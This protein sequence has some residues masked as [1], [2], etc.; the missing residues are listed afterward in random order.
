MTRKARAIGRPAAFILVLILATHAGT[1]QEH[2]NCGHPVPDRSIRDC[3]LLVD[4]GGTAAD[5]LAEFHLLRGLAHFMKEETDQALADFEVA[6][7]LAPD[8]A[9]PLAAR[10]DVYF[11]R[12]QFERSVTD[13]EQAFRRNPNDAAVYFARHLALEKLGRPTAP[14][15]GLQQP[16]HLEYHVALHL[17]VRRDLVIRDTAMFRA[18]VASEFAALDQA[19]ALNPK[20]GAAYIKRAQAFVRFG[21][22]LAEADRVLVDYDQALPNFGGRQARRAL[23]DYDQAIRVSPALADAF[24]ARG[25][26]LRVRGDYDPAIADLSEALRLQ[27]DDAKTS[28][29][30]G[31]AYLSK[32]DYHRAAADFGEAIRATPKER[33]LYHRR[34][35]AHARMGE[36]SKAIADL[37]KALET[38][39][40]VNQVYYPAREELARLGVSREEIRRWEA[41]HT[42]V[43]H[44]QGVA[45]SPIVIGSAY[46]DRCL[47][48]IDKGEYDLAT[49]D[50]DQAFRVDPDPQY[51]EQKFWRRARAFIKRREFDRAIADFS[52]AIAIKPSNNDTWFQRGEAFFGKG[53]YDRAIADFTEVIRLRPKHTAAYTARGEAYAQ[54]Q[55]FARAIADY[56]ESIRQSPG[57]GAPHYQRGFAYEQIGQSD[58]AIADYRFVASFK[59]DLVR[60]VRMIKLNEFVLSEEG[61][62]RLGAAR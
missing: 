38:G 15:T 12:G 9:A 39:L 54:K 32:G 33:E 59:R 47:D 60:G 2:G 20:D 40:D 10:G 26:F 62:K 61:L 50:C 21:E 3:T 19:I 43:R 45:H 28:A 41:E 35:L 57:A 16:P 58:S 8:Q 30:R 48:Q 37:R 36:R 52:Q 27:P 24:F 55:E 31:K 49:Q 11:Q 7:R 6:I 5:K 56:D 53:D 51:R 25:E 14:P 22:T 34:G 23:A 18:Q 13:Y 4:R 29:S 17:R 1:A 44:Q 42:I 46:F